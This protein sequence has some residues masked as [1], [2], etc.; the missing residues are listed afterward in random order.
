MTIDNQRQAKA[1]M[2]KMKAQLPIPARAT[3]ELVRVLKPHDLKLKR[4]QELSIK[5][6][7]Y[8][9]DTGGI[10]CDVTPTIL[11]SRRFGPINGRGKRE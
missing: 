11:W 6:L 9:G 8:M 2:C 1:L 10:S 4:G 5:N 7:F 3:S